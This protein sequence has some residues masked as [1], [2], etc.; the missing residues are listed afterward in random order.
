MGNGIRVAGGAASIILAMTTGLEHLAD[1]LARWLADRRG[2]DAVA[3]DDL[4]R[5]SVGYSSLTVLFRARYELDRPITEHLV[6]R[7]APAGPGIHLAYDLAVEHAAQ[8][9]AGAAGVPI[10]AP[11]TLESDPDWLGAPFLVMPRIDGHIVGEVPAFD[12]WVLGLAPAQRSTLHD[13]FVTALGAIHGAPV[14]PAVA[15]GVPVRDDE[16]E[17]DHWDAYLRWSSDDAPVAVLADALQWCRAH[18]P[19][20]ETDPPLVLCW[21]DV[22]FGNVVFGDDLRAR[23]VLDW[24]MTSVGSR[25]HD[26]AWYTALTSTITRFAGQGVEGFPDRD[27]TIAQYEERTGHRLHDLEWYETFAMVRSTAIMTRIN[28]LAIESGDAPTMPIHDNPLLDL[29]R[30]RTTGA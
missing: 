9:A 15:G 28:L 24:D 20:R 10:A 4:T 19:R 16:A 23:A 6:L 11:I 7:M 14:E 5:P 18:V 27:G 17:L 21:G 2:V 30:E 3:V 1:G 26:V 25:E 13:Q 22:R 12:E 8:G 29:L